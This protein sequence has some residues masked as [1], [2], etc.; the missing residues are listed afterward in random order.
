MIKAE[1]ESRVNLMTVKVS[2]ETVS[3]S[4]GRDSQ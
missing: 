1:Q 3:V 4:I 2:A